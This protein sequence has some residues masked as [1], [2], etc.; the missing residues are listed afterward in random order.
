MSSQL[1]S[2][3]VHL[4][5]L[6]T[7]SRTLFERSHFTR[8]IRFHSRGWKR[9]ISRAMFSRVSCVLFFSFFFF[10]FSSGIAICD[11]ERAGMD[12]WCVTRVIG[13]SK[14]VKDGWKFVLEIKMKVWELGNY[15]YYFK[16]YLWYL[17]IS[18]VDFVSWKFAKYTIFWCF[19][20][21]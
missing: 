17:G 3:A 5:F 7:S 20:F 9:N 8:S 19:E 1:K 15:Y 10:F 14:V 16:I 4:F 6:R 18:R 11:S 13:E 21:C 2:S 12:L